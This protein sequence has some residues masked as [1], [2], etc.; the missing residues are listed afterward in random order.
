MGVTPVNTLTIAY[1]HP[2]GPAYL[3]HS[4]DLTITPTLP[5]VTMT[6]NP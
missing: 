2:T 1:P 5:Y 6:P 4:T 3:H